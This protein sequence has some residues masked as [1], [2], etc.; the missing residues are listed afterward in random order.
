MNPDRQTTPPPGNHSKPAISLVVAVY[1]KPEALRLVLAACARQS[2][3]EFEVII[4]DD[5]SG[6]AIADVVREARKQYSYP[7]IHLWHEDAEWRKNVMLNNAIRTA[8]SD[9]ICFIDG[10]CIPSRRFLDDHWSQR[11]AGKI[12]LG[13][14]VETSHRWSEALTVEDV[15]TGKFERLGWWELLDGLKGDAL[16]LED[17]IRVRSPFLRALLLR[18]VHT[19]LGSNFSVFKSDLVAINGF[20]ELYDGPGCGEDSDIQYRLSLIGTTGKSL[21]NMAILFHLYH[22]ATT[23]SEACRRRFEMVRQTREPRCSHGLERLA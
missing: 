18:N 15:T 10:D 7:V 17:S 21:R 12:L 5:G 3:G 4:A 8:R 2:I 20:D 19:L 11:A 13:R 23:V 9:Y 1:D 16:R 6:P 22:L 14:R